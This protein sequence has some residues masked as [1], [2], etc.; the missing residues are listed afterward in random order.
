MADMQIFDSEF[1]WKQTNMKLRADNAEIFEFVKSA[2]MNSRI[3]LEQY[4][5][6]H[7]DFETSFE[8]LEVDPLAPEFIREMMVAGLTCGVGPM[9]AVAGGLSEVATDVMSL[10]GCKLSIADNGGDISIKGEHLVTVGVYAGENNVAKRIGFKIKVG[11][12]PLGVC[13]SAGSVGHSVSLGDADAVIAFSGSAFLS[14]AAATAVA[15]FVKRSDPEGSVQR[16]LEKAENITGLSGCMVF[17]GEL[18]GRVGKIPDSVEVI[19]SNL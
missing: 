4:I 5:I 12:L 2:V 1:H 13:T 9:A 16:A 8:P 10:N 3:L 19:D 15:N 7:P 18:V 6:T 17:F 14:D 11:E